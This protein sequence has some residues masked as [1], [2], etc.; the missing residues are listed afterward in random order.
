[1]D[2]SFF[3]LDNGIRVLLQSVDSPV[4]HACILVKAGARDEEE[5]Q[6]GLAHFIEHLLF[7]KTK[8]RSTNQILN[9][10]ESIGADLNAYTTKEYT[11][12]HASFLHPYLNR[13]LDLFE[14]LIYHSVFPEDELEKEKGVILDE[15]GSYQDSPEDSIMDDFEDLVFQGHHL[16]HNILGVEND[17]LSFDKSHIET[18]MKSHY[19][20]AETVVAVSGQYTIAQVKR[21]ANKYFGQIPASEKKT[22]PS[23]VPAFQ[24]MNEAIEKPI[25]Q[26]HHVLGSRSFAIHDEQRI[27]MSL[28][29]NYLG[30]MGMSSKLNLVIR[31]KHGIAYT[32]ESNFA[33]YDDSGLFSV[34]FGTDAEKSQKA[35]RLILQEFKKLRERPF[36]SM[37]LH[38][39]KKKFK[40]QI[41]LGEE[42]RLGLI[43]AQ[44]KNVLDFG[45]TITLPQ[46]FMQIDQV[47]SEQLTEIAQ[48]VLS[49]KNLFSLS[50]IPPLRTKY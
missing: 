42:N 15:I 38:Q 43:I 10:L 44:A 32:V 21:A 12:L 1:M 11:C 24:P 2:F 31:E 19:A 25:N 27:G 6:H 26:V 29:N 16:G 23:Q 20:T 41:A 8:K 46:L 13:T 4:S 35:E 18:F 5:G 34:Y 14:D 37:Q 33:A 49:E 39:A 45:E 3:Q 9:R 7:K 28:L 40:G 22:L 47:T 17:V 50:F 30:G 48:Y 36:G